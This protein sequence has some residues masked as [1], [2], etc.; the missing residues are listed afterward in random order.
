MGRF[1]IRITKEKYTSYVN[2]SLNKKQNMEEENKFY[3]SKISSQR[4]IIP[5]MIIL[6][7]SIFIIKKIFTMNDD[8]ILIFLS[9]FLFLIIIV[10]FPFFIYWIISLKNAKKS[11]IELPT[12]SMIVCKCSGLFKTKTELSEIKYD[13]IK[14]I[15]IFF[16][17]QYYC[18]NVN[19][20]KKWDVWKHS[21]TTFGLKISDNS[22]FMDEI[23]LYWVNVSRYSHF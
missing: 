10:V 4:Y 11:Y 8:G 15:K 23:K 17:L 9:L 22:R 20:Y 16:D 13:D 3:Q 2:F 14:E 12:Q 6:L 7:S 5:F 21:A 18:Y 1:F 19:I